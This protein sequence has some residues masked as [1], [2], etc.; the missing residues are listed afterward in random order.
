MQEFDGI[1][2][3]VGAPIELGLIWLH[4]LGADASD[5]LPI[6]GELDLPAGTRFVFPNAP[7]RPVTINGGIVMRAWYD[8]LGFGPDAPEDL[9]GLAASAAFVRGL[10]DRE[11]GRGLTRERIV[12]AGFSQ[13]GAV[14]L[15]AG[16]GA[17][18]PLGGI[19]GLSTYL[20]AAGSLSADGGI[21]TDVPVL[22]AHGTGDPVIPLALAE[23]AARTLVARGVGVDWTT[24]AMGHEVCLPELAHI[25]GW[26]RRFAPR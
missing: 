26:L 20:P 3:E 25:N 22:L 19:L 10:I 23:L 14:V 17:P 15:H 13:G 4:G 12:L 8:I 6:I 24:Y 9:A 2:R 11:V 16:L 18:G 1:E 5:F 21:A 7:M